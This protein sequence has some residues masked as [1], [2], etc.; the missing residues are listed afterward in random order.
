MRLRIFTLFA[1]F[2]LVK[3]VF[4][5]DRLEVVS[6]AGNEVKGNTMV[7]NYTIGEPIV[8]YFENN[9]IVLS[10][11]FQQVFLEAI[12]TGIDHRQAISFT[13]YPNP[14]TD[15]ITIDFGELELNNYNI[16]ITLA[17][18]QIMNTVDWQR[19]NANQA[20]VNFSD[21]AAAVYIVSIIDQ[22]SNT[23]IPEFKVIKYPK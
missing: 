6:S 21:L 23:I 12:T 20:L 10:Q 16:K 14:T 8:E 19:L 18:G 22:D 13:Y 3:T 1:F 5:Q 11:G 9:D 15:K 7:V 2:F 4:A 17:D